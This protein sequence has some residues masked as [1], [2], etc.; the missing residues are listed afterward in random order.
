[1]CFRQHSNFEFRT[2]ATILSGYLQLSRCVRRV[3]AQTL[4][5]LLVEIPRM[6]NGKFAFMQAMKLSI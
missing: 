3:S 5:V 2:E 6:Q 1:M 4:Q